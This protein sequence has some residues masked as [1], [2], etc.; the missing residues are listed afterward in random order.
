VD[1][2]YE[3]WKNDEAAPFQGWDFS[4]IADRTREEDPPWDYLARA[5]ML[6]GTADSLLDMGTGGGEMLAGLAPLPPRTIA[7]EFYKP[8]VG[9]AQQRLGPLGVRVVEADEGRVLPFADE[10]FDLVI[11]RHGAFT[12]SELFRI[13]KPTGR[14]LSQQVGGNDRLDLLAEFGIEPGPSDWTLG[15]TTMAFEQ[16]GFTVEQAELWQGSM[17]FLDVG[18]LVYYLKA[19]PWMVPDFSVDAYRPTLQRLHGKLASGE[20]LTCTK[21]SFLVQAQKPA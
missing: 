8:N 7:T 17:E 10:G 15:Q 21:V 11:N 4:Y 18:A 5:R 12:V 3:W 16:A 14:F 19:I 6:I 2:A 1:S 20:P 9:V 13:L